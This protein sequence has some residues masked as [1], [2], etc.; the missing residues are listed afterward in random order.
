[1]ALVIR[2]TAEGV[3]LTGVAAPSPPDDD[4]L[5]ATED[6]ESLA[7]D[8]GEPIATERPDAA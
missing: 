5:L 3:R 4:F 2:L 7:A 6:G 8:A 1:M